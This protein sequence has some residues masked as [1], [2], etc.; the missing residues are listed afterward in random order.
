M[1]VRKPAM[2]K[3]RILTINPGSTSTKVAL[4]KGTESVVSATVEHTSRE[5][6]SSKKILD[7][8]SLR[9]Q[10][11]T[12]FLEENRITNVDAVVGRGGLLRPLPGGTYKVNDR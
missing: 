6:A 11:I 9:E 3:L 5:I 8:K 10:A 7:Q 4:Y 12:V 1:K 2:Q